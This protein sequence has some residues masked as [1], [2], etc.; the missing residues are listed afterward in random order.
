MTDIPRAK[1]ELMRIVRSLTFVDPAT[2][3]RIELVVES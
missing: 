1:V 2:S 3:R